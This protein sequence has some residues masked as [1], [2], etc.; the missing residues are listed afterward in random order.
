MTRRPIFPKRMMRDG[1]DNRGQRFDRD[2]HGW[3]MRLLAAGR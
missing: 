2:A 1:G 3:T